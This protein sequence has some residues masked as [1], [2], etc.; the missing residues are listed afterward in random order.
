MAIPPHLPDVS[1]SSEPPPGVVSGCVASPAA[2]RIDRLGALLQR[3]RLEKRRQ[4]RLTSRALSTGDVS[5]VR[6]ALA[7]FR[8]A[9]RWETALYASYVRAVFAAYA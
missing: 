1:P 9:R 4:L 3:A 8:R 5:G 6:A 2:D 7:R